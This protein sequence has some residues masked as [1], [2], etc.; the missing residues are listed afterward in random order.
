MYN[1]KDEA[2]QKFLE[3]VLDQNKEGL[4]F[5]AFHSKDEK[6][7]V[8]QNNE[9]RTDQIADI[10]KCLEKIENAI[11]GLSVSINFKPVLSSLENQTQILKKSL[12]EQTLAR[13]ISEGS[14]E[15]DKKSAQY[16][17]T[18]GREI[19]SDV[20]GKTIKEGGY[21]DF[22]T[23]GN[24]LAGQSKRVRESETNKIK[25]KP[26]ELG[27]KT[28][29]KGTPGSIEPKKEEK[30]KEGDEEITGFGTPI[31]L[32]KA[33]GSRVKGIFDFM[34]NKVEKKDKQEP[35]PGVRGVNPEADNIQSSQEIIA[36]SSEKDLELTKENKNILEQQLAEL[37]KISAA[38]EP[39]IPSDLPEGRLKPSPASAAA[40]GGE[41]SGLGDILSNVGDL[42]KKSGRTLLGGAKSLGRGA[43]S[44]GGTVAKFAG[45]GAGRML[46]AAAAVGIGAYTAYKGYSAAEDSKQAKLEEVQAKVDS[47][48]LSTEE[49]SAERKKIGNTATVEKSG[50]VGEGSGMAAGAVAGGLAGAKLGAT[51]GTF[52]GGPAG[53]VVGAGIGTIAGGA[54]GAFAGSKAGKVVGEKV[55]EGINAVK[56]FFG[57]GKEEELGTKTKQAVSGTESTNIQFSEMEFAKKDPENYKKFVEFREQ[58][59]EEIY[60]KILEDRKLT[61]KSPPQILETVREMAGAKA[62]I[63]AVKKFQK[64]IE[65]AG[66]GKI[67]TKR[68]GEKLTPSSSE[69]QKAVTPKTGTETALPKTGPVE[70]NRKKSSES[71]SIADEPVVPGKPFSKNQMA[72]IELSKGSGNKYSPEIEAQY[73]KQKQASI[74]PAAAPSTGPVVA[75]E[76][77][78]N[79]D[80]TRSASRPPPAATPIV[81]SSVNNVNT[82]S[83][84]P[85]KPSPRPERTGSSL[86]RYNDRIAAY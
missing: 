32:A 52:V 13:K 33:I 36:D 67:E 61:E 60:K 56:S 57:L 74:A 85:I 59:T 14:L 78:D 62:K 3:K 50:A 28:A 46:G 35:D 23:A 6:E 25:L 73:A 10:A 30:N 37:K 1:N 51:I 49:A 34:T 81:S 86:D 43:L 66:A 39:K 72:A 9:E 31:D 80:L 44:L 19:T 18:S 16:R 27:T 41:G 42:G 84:V 75:K 63:E 15:Y 77:T 55:G 21:I 69:S 8:Q 76:S 2:F 5:Q 17:N 7:A 26:L 45:S 48:E 70:L 11:T 79:A 54:L 22:E 29:I 12:E 68:E 64:E 71:I 65:T 83:F 47:G 24:R 58:K 4:A 20:S 40:E 38:L 53:T 82:Q